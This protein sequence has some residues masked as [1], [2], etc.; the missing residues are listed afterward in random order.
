MT[1]A[2]DSECVN[3]KTAKSNQNCFDLY[4]LKYLYSLDVRPVSRKWT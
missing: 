2:G 4:L 3:A 1:V